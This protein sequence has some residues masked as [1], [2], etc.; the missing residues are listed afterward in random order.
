[1]LSRNKLREILSKHQQAFQG[2]KVLPSKKPNERIKNK[3][4]KTPSEK[5]FLENIEYSDAMNHIGVTGRRTP[6]EYFT[7]KE[8]DFHY[9]KPTEQTDYSKL[10]IF[11]RAVSPSEYE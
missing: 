10:D 6:I 3:N 9:K 2:S 11:H 5:I 4:L 7:Y 8:D 1:M